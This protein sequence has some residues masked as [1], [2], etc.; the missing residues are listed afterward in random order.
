LSL[1]LMLSSAPRLTDLLN[2]LS[3]LADQ[4]NAYHKV[5]SY[6]EEA[7]QALDES[8]NDDALEKMLKSSDK[9]I[10]LDTPEAGQIR[11][12]LAEVIR[13]TGITHTTD[14]DHHDDDH[15]SDDDHES[16]HED[17]HDDDD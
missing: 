12:E 15:D 14:S 3:L 16:C 6:L 13:L 17:D 7:Q 11:L 2:E 10:K 8:D 1:T 5:F 9:L 4:D